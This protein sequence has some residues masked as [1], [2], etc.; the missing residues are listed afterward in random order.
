MNLDW[1]AQCAWWGLYDRVKLTELGP[2]I[3]STHRPEFEGLPARCSCGEADWK[4]CPNIL[5]M[6]E[7]CFGPSS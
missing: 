2:A 5:V 1:L 3:M 4:L 6:V 7:R